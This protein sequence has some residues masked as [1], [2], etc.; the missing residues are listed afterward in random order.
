MS[1]ERL[2]SAIDRSRCRDTQPNVTWSSGIPEGDFN[3]K[4]VDYALISYDCFCKG[5][6]S[7]VLIGLYKM[8]VKIKIMFRCQR[9]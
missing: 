9:G 6:F 5:I 2:Q 4:D 8:K 7:S 1:S 3:V